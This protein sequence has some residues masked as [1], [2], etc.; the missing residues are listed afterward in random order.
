MVLGIVGR[1]RCAIAFLF[2]FEE[3]PLTP[4]RR[5]ARK[6]YAVP[7]KIMLE[8]LIKI[9]EKALSEC[10]DQMTPSKTRVPRLEII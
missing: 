10:R 7:L 3:W 8:M 5:C 1:A 9:A 4:R 2:S 6:K